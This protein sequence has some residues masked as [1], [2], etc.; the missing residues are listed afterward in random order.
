MEAPDKLGHFSDPKWLPDPTSQNISADQTDRLDTLISVFIE[1]LTLN[2]SHAIVAGVGPQIVFS[3]LGL[4]PTIS[5][6]NT[7]K[8]R[9]IEK[10][11]SKICFRGTYLFFWRNEWIWV[12]L[13]ERTISWKVRHIQW[14]APLTHLAIFIFVKINVEEVRLIRLRNHGIQDLCDTS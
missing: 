3:E 11:V 4:S 9:Y 2:L 10:Y 12:E 5:S 14:A 1:L 6:L 7:R 8:K 13:C